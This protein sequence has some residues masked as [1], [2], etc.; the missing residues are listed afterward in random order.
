MRSLGVDF[1]AVCSVAWAMFVCFLFGGGACEL[2]FA[3]LGVLGMVKLR[4]L[5]NRRAV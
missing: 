4:V 5:G 2:L 3:A 1:S